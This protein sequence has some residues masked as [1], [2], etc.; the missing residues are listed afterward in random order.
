MVRAGSSTYPAYLSSSKRN[1][2]QIVNV[3]SFG[4]RIYLDLDP[5]TNQSSCR[6]DH[7]RS[8]LRFPNQLYGQCASNYRSSMSLKG[9]K[10]AEGAYST[11]SE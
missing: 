5:V 11:T 8:N 9:T 7:T 3:T 2:E 1:L 10:A 6:T 4:V